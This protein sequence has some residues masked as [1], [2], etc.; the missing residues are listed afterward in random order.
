MKQ[1]KSQSRLF[2]VG[3]SLV[4]VWALLFEVGRRLP[5]LYT[6]SALQ[7]RALV[8]FPLLLIAMTWLAFIHRWRSTNQTGYR[9]AMAGYAASG[10]RLRASVLMMVGLVFVSAVLAWTSIIV[11]IWFTRWLVAER[12]SLEFSVVAVESG[13]RFREVRLRDMRD[14]SE[15]SLP[16]TG[17]FATSPIRRGELICAEVKQS[18]AGTLV[19]KMQ[20]GSC[21]SRH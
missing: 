21:G 1:D 4:V 2:A 14:G 3:L 19:E 18:Y 8:V 17:G 20:S 9:M 12:T 10:P 13:G 7:V 5:F 15:A 6:E 16:L 11:P